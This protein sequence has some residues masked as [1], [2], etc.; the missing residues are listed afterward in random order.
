MTLLNRLGIF[1]VSIN[2]QRTFNFW[3]FR[4]VAF[5]LRACL[6]VGESCEEAVREIGGAGTTGCLRLTTIVDVGAR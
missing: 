6:L 2:Q 5:E 3:S 4:G 1:H